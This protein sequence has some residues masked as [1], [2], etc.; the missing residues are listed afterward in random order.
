MVD[1]NLLC[2]LNRIGT[3]WYYRQAPRRIYVWK[4]CRQSFCFTLLAWSI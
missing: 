3:H 4:C 1:G 2:D